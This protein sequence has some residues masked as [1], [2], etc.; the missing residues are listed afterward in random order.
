MVPQ[1]S[2]HWGGV[3]GGEGGADV[4]DGTEAGVG[5]DA[6][7]DAVF[8]AGVG[9]GVVAGVGVVDLLGVAPPCT[10]PPQAESAN[11]IALLP[12]SRGEKPFIFNMRVSAIFH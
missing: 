12:T 2:V 5:F 11:R 9:A 6:V 10:S 3:A 4:C 8:D 1:A 7:F